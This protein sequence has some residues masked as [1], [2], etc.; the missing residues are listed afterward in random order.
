VAGLSG[1]GK[2]TIV[3][4]LQRAGELAWD[5]DDL[6]FWRDR[7]TGEA[8]ARP[9]VRPDGWVERYGWVIDP[10]GV[11]RCRDDADGRV[12]Y[13]AG[14]AENEADVWGLFDTVVYLVTD[15][16]TIRERL[17][18]R[19][20]NDFGRT[21]EELAMVLGW[22]DVLEAHYRKAGATIIDAGQP[23]P[24]VVEAVRSAGAASN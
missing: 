3:Q 22:N 16:A 13:L 8:V 12:G 6:S 20:G 10:E 7:Q 14:G 1:T 23:L 19:T 11:R 21:D 2:S 15:D 24:A 18:T 5:A 17:A 4:H 9:A